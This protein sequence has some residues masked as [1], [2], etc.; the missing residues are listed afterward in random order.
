M[1]PANSLEHILLYLE[2]GHMR[3]RP[4]M[5]GLLFAPP[6]TPIG[7]SIFDRLLDW[8]YRSGANFDFFCVGY[9]NWTEEKGA[10]PVARITAKPGLTPIKFY[11][12]ARA[13]H[14]IRKRVEALSSWR[15][16][17]EADLLLLNAMKDLDTGKAR[18]EFDE[19]IALD[20]DS[21]V[22]D[23][24]FATP[25]RLLERVCQAADDA[26]ASGD[27]LS[28]M[29]F[30]DKEVVR[31]FLRGALSKL[32]DTLKVGTLLGARHFI[33]GGHLLRV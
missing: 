32:V 29:D 10:K 6:K 19:M 3:E 8:H 20:V 24:V 1:V 28:V 22:R 23:N 5:C 31:T 21:L 7:K 17:G 13:F 12:N 30:S 27:Q 11:Y 25:A 18:L 2:E 15:Y 4:W 33:V 9:G 14:D 16:S 26:A